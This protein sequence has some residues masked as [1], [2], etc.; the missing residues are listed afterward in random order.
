MGRTG[1]LDDVTLVEPKTLAIQPRVWNDFSD[2][3]N[4]QLS[5]EAVDSVLK[6][7]GLL[8][9]VLKEYGCHLFGEGKSLF[10][11]RRLVV[12]TQQS[13]VGAKPYLQCCW[14]LVSKWEICE[15]SHP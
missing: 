10:C 6:H 12:Y 2:W 5:A 15:L 1:Y 14:D 8:A 13:F 11:F 9:Q 3:L 7:F 4:S